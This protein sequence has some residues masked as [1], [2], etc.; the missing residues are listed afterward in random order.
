[1]LGK[2]PFLTIFPDDA[3]ARFGIGEDC[4]LG[5]GL[6]TCPLGRLASVLVDRALAEH[7]PFPAGWLRL[8]LAMSGGL[9]LLTLLIAAAAA[10]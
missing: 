7:I 3:V 1:M 10:L 8:R 4:T 9:G 6:A 5:W 2:S